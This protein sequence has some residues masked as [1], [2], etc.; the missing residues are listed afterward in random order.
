MRVSDLITQLGNAMD[1]YGD[2]SVEVYG[3]DGWEAVHG[4]EIL[5]DAPSSYASILLCDEDAYKAFGE[6]KKV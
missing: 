4:L 2:I 6:D 1:K 5:E 3:D